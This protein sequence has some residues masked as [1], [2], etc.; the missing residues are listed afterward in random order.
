MLMSLH[1]SQHDGSVIIPANLCHD[2]WCLLYLSFDFLMM[3]HLYNVRNNTFI[4]T[5]TLQTDKNS[6][7]GGLYSLFVN[8]FPIM[9]WK[10]SKYQGYCDIQCT[11]LEATFERILF[12]NDGEKLF[13]THVKNYKSKKLIV[14][15]HL[16]ITTSLAFKY[17]WYISYI[18]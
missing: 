7:I 11:I 2:K 4:L 16:F 8:P 12:S 14:Q 17:L 10:I 3:L 18:N 15:L 9:G 13:L 5:G 1:Y 6:I